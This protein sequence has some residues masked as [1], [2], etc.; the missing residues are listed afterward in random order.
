MP[1]MNGVDVTKHLRAK[2]PAALI[3][4]VSIED[5]NE[6]FVAAGANGFLLKPYQYRDILALIGE[7]TLRMR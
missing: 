4:G 1:N 7:P 6:D 2:F 3:I 5:R